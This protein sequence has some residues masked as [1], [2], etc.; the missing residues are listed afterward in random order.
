MQQDKRQRG[1]AEREVRG[2]LI[3]DLTGVHYLSN[4]EN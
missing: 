2:Q 4:H 1:K 3:K